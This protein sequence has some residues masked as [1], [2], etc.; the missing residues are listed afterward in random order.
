MQDRANQIEAKTFNQMKKL[1]TIVPLTI[2]LFASCKTNYSEKLEDY[3]TVT[4]IFDQSEIED[5]TTILNFFNSQ[6][7]AIEGVCE[8]EIATCYQRFLKR[9][10]ETEERGYYD[11][12][13]SLPEQHE[14]YEQIGETTF[15]QIW[16]FGYRHICHPNFPPRDT[17]RSI[18]LN[19]NGKYMMFLKKRGKRNAIMKEYYQSILVAGDLSPISHA[20]G[21][22]DFINLDVKDIKNQLVI[23]IHF[24]SINDNRFMICDFRSG[25]RVLPI[26]LTLDEE[27]NFKRTNK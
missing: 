15:N 9:M 7:C 26:N 24:L 27:G 22:Y 23:A 14:M 5:L 6:I 1:L 25:E 17:T 20:I 13:I 16:V 4:D 11:M 19:Y 18:E 21:I 10:G 2:F 3:R 8:T 12:K